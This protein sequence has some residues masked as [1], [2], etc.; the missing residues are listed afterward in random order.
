MVSAAVPEV[1][2]VSLKCRRIHLGN[3]SIL[4]NGREKMWGTC[5]WYGIAAVNVQ[6]LSI[7]LF[8]SF[9][10]TLAWQMGHS[11]SSLVSAIAVE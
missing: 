5:G 11:T 8:I 4:V 6:L 2:C 10:G 1:H 3:L 9:W 7:C